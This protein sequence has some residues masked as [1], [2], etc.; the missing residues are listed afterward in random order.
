MTTVICEGIAVLA[1]VK[2]STI[3]RQKDQ[4][5]LW[6]LRPVASA[7]GISDTLFGGLMFLFS[8]GS[9]ENLVFYKE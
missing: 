9:F 7:F 1:N 8:N 4:S 5:K 3:C 2:K 6:L